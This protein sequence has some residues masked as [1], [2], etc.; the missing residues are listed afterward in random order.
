MVLIGARIH[1]ARTRHR[2]DDCHK[3]IQPGEQYLDLFGS[4][5]HYEKPY[6]IKFH[7]LCQN[8]GT[9][10]YHEKIAKAF[11]KAGLEYKYWSPDHS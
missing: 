4:A 2:C 7:I 3:A 8:E 1:T 9:Y 11:E 6:H 10:S 5:H